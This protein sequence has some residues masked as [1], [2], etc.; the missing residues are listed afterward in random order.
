MASGKKSACNVAG[1]LS[2]IPGSGRYPGEGNGS[3]FQCSC[4]EKKP[5]VLQFMISQKTWS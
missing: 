3:L 5:G 2:L 1:A 4:M